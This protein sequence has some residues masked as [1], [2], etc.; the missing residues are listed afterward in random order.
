ML[1]TFQRHGGKDGDALLS[2]LD[3][4]SKGFPSVEACDMDCFRSLRHDEEHVSEAVL[5]EPCHDSEEFLELLAVACFEGGSKRLD[6]LFDEC[7][8]VFC[9]HILFL[10]NNVS[11]CSREIPGGCFS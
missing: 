1:V 3:E 6:L 10:Q 7:F 9:L 4:A 8:C 2:R 11:A 5:V